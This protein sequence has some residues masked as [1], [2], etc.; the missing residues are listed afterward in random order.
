MPHCPFDNHS[1]KS[2]FKP[3]TITSWD[4]HQ[5]CR[6]VGN[7]SRVQVKQALVKQGMDR[8]QENSHLEWPDHAPM[9]E[10]EVLIR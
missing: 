7:A 6:K 8:E 10:T 3:E 5:V 4:I 2:R 9:K 1:R